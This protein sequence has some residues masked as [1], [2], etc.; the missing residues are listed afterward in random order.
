MS[1]IIGIVIGAVVVVLVPAA[2]TFVK[3]QITSVKND[4]PSIISAVESA[5]NTVVKLQNK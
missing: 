2:Y 5:A 3:K 1:V 4:A